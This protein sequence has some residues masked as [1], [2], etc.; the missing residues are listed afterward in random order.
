MQSYFC[1][2]VTFLDPLFHGR[3]DENEPEWPPSPMRVY[4]ALL[5][6]SQTGCRKIQWSSAK[7]DAFLWLERQK[8]LLIITPSARPAA[9]CKLFVPNNDSDKKIDRHERL[10]SKDS[11][12]YRM[13]DGETL[14][15]LWAIDE[16]Q[17]NSIPCAKL[18]CH[19][20]RQIM[21]LGWGI[22]QVVG[23]GLILQDAEVAALQGKRWRMWDVNRP[24]LRTWRVPMQGTLQNLMK[25]HHAFLQRVDGKRYSPPPKFMKYDTMAYIHETELPP[26]SYAVFELPEGVVFHQ[27][28]A[29]RVAAMLR[30][31]TCRLAKRD[32]H[33]FPGGS[34][35]YVAGHI[36]END[37]GKPRLSYLPL[38]TIGH[39]HSDGMIRRV[40]IAEPFGGNG[41]HASWAQIR[42][43]GALMTDQDNCDRGTLYD[44]WRT[45]SA[46]VI[47]LYACE[48]RVWHSVT[49]VILPG[50]D[51][52][53]TL[54][55][56]KDNGPTKAERLLFKCLAHAG[57]PL[58]SLE[59]VTLRKA[60]FWPGSQHPMRYHR[61]DYLADHRARPG[62]HVRLVFRERLAG[63]LSIGA[64]RHCGLGIL[65]R[66]ED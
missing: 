23:D 66:A 1:I 25:I 49:P 30:S 13:L 40:M 4:Q 42:L 53:K 29:V 46:E 65:A 56:S 5:A 24:G 27:E 15:Y 58:G 19:E 10:T 28:D 11:R 14:Y 63:P 2:S 17:A 36:S 33:T 22:D 38:P 64:G 43:R 9:A 16:G 47:R 31:L 34:E 35:Q 37:R 54:R 61:P 3:G 51:D 26:R 7:E 48:G 60:P 18:L 52:F 45:S 39:S 41:T 32:T 21:A 59:S 6:G 8:P 55:Q 12:P 62:W 57:I 44:L 50:Y 20:A